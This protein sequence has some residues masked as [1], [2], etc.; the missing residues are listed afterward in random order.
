MTAQSF[1]GT[2]GPLHPSCVVKGS[3]IIYY[4]LLIDSL[5]LELNVMDALVQHVIP[6]K[7]TGSSQIEMPI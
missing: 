6:P 7:S 1:W 4:D 3:M 5:Y 2:E